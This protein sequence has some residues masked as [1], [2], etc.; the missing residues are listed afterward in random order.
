MLGHLDRAT[1][2]ASMDRMNSIRAIAFT[3][4]RSAAATVGHE[5][6]D[7]GTND[8]CRQPILRRRAAGTSE[9]NPV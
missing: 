4:R 2:L 8:C 7:Q 6:S 9:S 5:R 1:R 3:L